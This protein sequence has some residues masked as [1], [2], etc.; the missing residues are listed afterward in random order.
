MSNAFVSK[1]ADRASDPR[2]SL[3]EIRALFSSVIKSPQVLICFD[4]Y[5]ENK[6]GEVEEE[7]EEEGRVNV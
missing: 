6:Q 7:E 2:S 3:T 5:F 4:L 1:C